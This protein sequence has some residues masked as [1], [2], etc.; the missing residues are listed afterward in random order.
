ML[1]TC[2]YSPIPNNVRHSWLSTP[3][4][5]AASNSHAIA[6]RN[7]G[8][9]KEAVTS[10]R[11]KRRNGR[12]VRATSQASGSV[13][14]SQPEILGVFL[15]DV[16][17]CLLLRGRIGLHNLDLGERLHARRQLHIRVH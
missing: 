17:G 14:L 3:L 7:G 11:M 6:P 4:L 2:S 8:V 10:T 15:F 16:G 13:I 1:K 9:T 5:G 12:S